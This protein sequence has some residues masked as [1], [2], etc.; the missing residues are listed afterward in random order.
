MSATFIS[1]NRNREELTDKQFA[2]RRLV[3][4]WLYLV[5]LMLMAIV[6]VGGATRLTG[7]GLSITEWQPVHGIIPPI[8]Q[9]QWQEEFEKYQQIAQYQQLNPGMTLAEFRHIFWW[10]WVHRLLARSVGLVVALPLIFFWLTGRIEKTVKWR[11]VGILLLGGFQGAIGW[12]MVAS[13]LGSSTLTSVS[14]YRLAVHL[15]MACMIIIAVLAL[16]RR[17]ADYTGKPASRNIQCFAGWIIVFALIQIYLGALVAGLHAGKVYN[18]W[19]LMDGYLIPNG[20][21]R[22]QPVWTNFFENVV[23]V[24]FVHRFFACFLLVVAAVHALN[25]EKIVPGTTHSRRAMLLLVLVLVQAVIGVITLLLAAPVFWG[26]IHQAFAL[27]V[28]SFAVA[29]WVA[30]KGALPAPEINRP[31]LI[32]RN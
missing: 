15:V 19:L 7:A 30:A 24:Q 3:R 27:V 13:G 11:L 10:E 23:T 17:L 6:L 8:G 4:N 28:L 32:A 5:F 21:W 14:Q 9:A 29:H 22:L 20:L 12:W 26:L 18:S 2:D 16:A 1:G 31:K 25:V